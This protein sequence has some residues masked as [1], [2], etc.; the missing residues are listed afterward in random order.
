[1][2]ARTY[3]RTLGVGAWRHSTLKDAVL[4]ARRGASSANA[5]ESTSALPLNERARSEVPEAY[6]LLSLDSS[7]TYMLL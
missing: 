4:P 5:G 7:R 6:T 3:Q 1:M 2:P